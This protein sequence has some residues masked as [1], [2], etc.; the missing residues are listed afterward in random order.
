MFTYIKARLG[1]HATQ[2]ALSTD[3]GSLIAA[4]SGQITWSAL[5]TVMIGSLPAIL[6]PANSGG[7]R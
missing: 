6:I 5:A 2:V 1:E 4:L 7:A 3:L